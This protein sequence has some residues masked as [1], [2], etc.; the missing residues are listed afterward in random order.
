M[1]NKNYHHQ[2]FQE[3]GMHEF[4]RFDFEQ[5]VLNCWAICDALDDVTAGVL[6]YEWTPDKVANVTIGLK[7]QFDVRFN[8]LFSMM[9]IGIH[10][11]KIL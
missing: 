1:W 9:E 11:R 4:N 3:I 7:E 6:E 5:Q 10:E 2:K 8:K